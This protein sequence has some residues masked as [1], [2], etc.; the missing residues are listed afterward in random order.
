M[1]NTIPTRFLILSDTHNFEFDQPGYTGPLQSPI[2]AVDVLI[3]C[4]DPTMCGGLSAYKKCL[5]MLGSFEAELKLVIAGNHDLSLD[6]MYWQNNLEEDDDPDEHQRAIDIMTGPLAKEAGVTY[7]EEG[8]HAFFLNNGAKFNIYVSAYQPEFGGWAFPYER[9]EDRYNTSDQTRKEAASIAKNPLPSFSEVDIVMT[10]GPPHG[11]LDE[12]D[13]G[14]AGCENMLHAIKRAKPLMHCFGHIH[15]GYGAKMVKW[16]EDR[17]DEIHNDY[18]RASGGSVTP[19]RETLFLN[20]AI[21]DGNNT[22]SSPCQSIMRV[23]E[24]QELITKV[25]VYLETYMKKYDGSHDFHHL[26]RVLGLSHAI[27]EELKTTKSASSVPQ[28]ALDP[29]IIT[30]SA[31]LHDVGDRKYLRKGDDPSIMVRDLL[32][33]FSAEQGLAEKVQIICS[34]VSY[35][36]EIKDRDHVRTLIAQ[37]PELAIVQDADRLDAIGAVGVGRVFAYGGALVDPNR[38]DMEGSIA[39]FEIKLFKLEGMMKTEP[40]RQMAKERIAI[41]RTFRKWWD[42]E[43]KVADLG[44]AILSSASQSHTE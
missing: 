20:A 16:D 26:E 17:C 22:S 27:Y 19:G 32:L 9:T 2:P 3:H 13:Q 6:G 33:G 29:T 7:L 4:G 38:Q 21:M 34:G 18:P 15:E 11:I 31:L 23:A 42:K 14:H 35:S 28:P 12:C 40:G 24:A 25:A 36:S 39:M 44:A 43:V 37:Y 10:H 1:V 30:L 41:L 8:T 5:R